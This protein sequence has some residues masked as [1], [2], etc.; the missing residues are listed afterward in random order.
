MDQLNWWLTDGH[1]IKMKSYYLFWS[2]IAIAVVVPQIIT[3]FA[4]HR[5]TDR[6]SEPIQVEIK[7]M[8]PYRVEYIK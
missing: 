7:K 8:P 4:Y 6:L 3:A 2:A 1:E 5:F